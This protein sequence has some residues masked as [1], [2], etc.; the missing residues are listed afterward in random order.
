[1]YIH[2]L[3]QN[4]S[5]GDRKMSDD[6]NLL[7]FRVAERHFGIENREVEKVINYNDTVPVEYDD[8]KKHLY[9]DKFL[10]L[11]NNPV[12]S[13]TLIIVNKYNTQL[14][15]S[16][17][18]LEDMITVSYAKLFTVPELIKEKQD[19]FII[20]GFAEYEGMFVT[21]ITFDYYNEIV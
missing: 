1:M 8:I 14:L 21:L 11:K 4:F 2:Y 19:P 6:I 17:P 5:P 18:V 16:I 12:Y 3:H 20:W 7:I 10:N 13:A 15:L 9:V